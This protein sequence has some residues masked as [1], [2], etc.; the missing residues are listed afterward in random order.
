MPVSTQMPGYVA[1]KWT[2]DPVHSHVGYSI[3]HFGVNRLQG[4]F[5][6]YE[7]EIVTA[8][9]PLDSTVTATIDTTSFSSGHPMRDDHMRGE[10]FL[11]AG[12][13]PTMTF[14]STGVREDGDGWLIDGELTLRGVT[15]PVTLKTELGGIIE[16]PQGGTVLALAVSTTLNR[17][18]FGVGM[19]GNVVVSEEVAITLGIEAKLQS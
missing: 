6:S 5:E 1:G 7:G 13:H 17:T 16:S 9:N 18:D 8:D 15:K 11:N 3:R 4:R 19:P 2:I 14:R 12:E 10:A